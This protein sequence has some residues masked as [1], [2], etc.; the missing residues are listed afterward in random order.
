MARGPPTAAGSA[1]AGPSK[2][3]AQPP[4]GGSWLWG[5][6]VLLP[7]PQG[8][9]REGLGEVTLLS[10]GPFCQENPFRKLMPVP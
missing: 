4:G 2:T 5:R 9:R 7:H 6:W 10:S 3:P 8:Q 1:R